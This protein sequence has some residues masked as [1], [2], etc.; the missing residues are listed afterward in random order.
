MSRK[1][2]FQISIGALLLGIIFGLYKVELAGAR[3]EKYAGID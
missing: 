2:K 3:E 1:Q